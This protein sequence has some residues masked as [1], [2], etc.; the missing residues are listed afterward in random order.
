M[1]KICTHICAIDQ[2]TATKYATRRTLHIFDIYHQTNMAAYASS[3]ALLLECIYRPHISAHSQC[4]SLIW[5][6]TKLW[7]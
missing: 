2:V 5:K 6:V 1:W 7:I 3:I 4:L